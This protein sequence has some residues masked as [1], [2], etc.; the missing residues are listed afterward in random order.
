MRAKSHEAQAHMG[1]TPWNCFT[2][3]RTTSSFVLLGLEFFLPGVVIKV[4]RPTVGTN[5]P[6]ENWRP[7]FA[8][9]ASRS[10]LIYLHDDFGRYNEGGAENAGP[11]NAGLDFDGP[12]SRAGKCKTGIWRTE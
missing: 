12:N 4:H 5:M 1:R 3:V 7:A 6:M 9:R 11:E 2:T 10:K 8:N